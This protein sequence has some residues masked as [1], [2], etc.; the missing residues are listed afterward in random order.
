MSDSAAELPEEPNYRSMAV[1]RAGHPA[2]PA[3]T[4]AA[5]G[6]V[7][8]PAR[9]TDPPQSRLPTGSCGPPA[10]GFRFLPRPGTTS[11][12]PADP[13]P[14]SAPLPRRV[15][16]GSSPGTGQ[17]PP[18]LRRTRLPV[19]AEYAELDAIVPDQVAGRIQ[20][21][22]HLDRPGSTRGADPPLPG[23]GQA[24]LRSADDRAAWPDL[25]VSVSAAPSSPSV[26]GAGPGAGTTTVVVSAGASAAV[27]LLIIAASLRGVLGPVVPASTPTMQPHAC[28]ALNVNL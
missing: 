9:Q 16:S 2:R 5:D 8:H 28:R 15:P 1:R 3:R 20:F 18:P 19:A 4:N 26:A 12:L 22:G 24:V 13:S 25:P 23:A 17:Y 27:G 7:C 11:P 21:D 14:G 6:P 10:E